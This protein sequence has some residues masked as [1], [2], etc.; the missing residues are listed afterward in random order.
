MEVSSAEEEG[1]PRKVTQALTSIVLVYDT[2][3]GTEWMLQAPDDICFSYNF[4]VQ[5]NEWANYMHCV[6]DKSVDLA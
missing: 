1:R 5:L 6:G 2:T 3:A 4:P